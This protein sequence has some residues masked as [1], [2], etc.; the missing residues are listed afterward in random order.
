MAVYQPANWG[1][2]VFAIVG[3]YV[4]V[5]SMGYFAAKRARKQKNG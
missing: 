2:V 1:L 5:G 4:L 3:S